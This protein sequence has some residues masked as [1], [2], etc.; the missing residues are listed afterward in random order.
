MPDI[1][2]C[3]GQGCPIKISCYRHMAE[4]NPYWQSYANLE[5]VCNKDSQY[6]R[7]ICNLCWVKMTRDSSHQCSHEDDAMQHGGVEDW[8]NGE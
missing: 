7:W 8:K 3:R 1:S 5:N 2:M 6:N 4:A